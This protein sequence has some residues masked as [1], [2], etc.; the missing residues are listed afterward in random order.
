MANLQGSRYQLRIARQ[1]REH[2]DSAEEQ[3]GYI[4]SYETGATV[5]GPGVRFMIFTS[6]CLLRCQY[7]H[8]PDTWHTKDG[9]LVTVSEVMAEVKKY[10]PMLG[11]MKGG[12]TIS[13]GEP[14][15]QMNFTWRLL[16]EIKKLGVH[17]ALDTAGLLGMRVPDEMMED[18]DMFLLD[19]KSWE[20]DLYKRLTAVDLAPTLEFAKRL[21]RI[22]KR[23][24]VRFV[25]VPKLTDKPD[26]VEGIAKF[27]APM[28]NVERVDVL[29]FH[30]LGAAKW[31]ALGLKYPLADARAPT[32]AEVQK[33]LDIFHAHGLNAI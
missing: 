32:R 26:N 29:P 16:M 33:V 19:V 23:V 7:C 9:H 31:Q 17:T 24:W 20:P 1:H 27:L 2:L 30:Q 14:M 22:N 4:H 6:G 12:V 13:G 21:N 15:V 3:T 5:D 8:N 10:A 25:L 28:K 11:R 18:I